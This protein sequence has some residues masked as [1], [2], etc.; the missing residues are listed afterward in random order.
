VPD[1]LELQAYLT[2]A[3]AHPDTRI[4]LQ[5]LDVWAQHPGG[6]MDTVTQ[7]LVDE[8]ETVRGRAQELL[9]QAFKGQ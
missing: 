8:D 1:P 5:A 9:D 6:S 4:R 7:A 3:Q 2:A